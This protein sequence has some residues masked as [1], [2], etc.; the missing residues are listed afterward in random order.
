MFDKKAQ[1]TIEY[2]VIIAIVVVIALVVVGLLLQVMDQGSGIPEQ[3]AKTAWKSAEPWAIVDWTVETDGDVV[4]VL[5]NNSFET[6]GL[7]EI[8]L[9]EFGDSNDDASNVP[10][11]STIRRTIN[12]TTN[13]ISESKYSYPKAYIVIDYNSGSINNKT[14]YGAA[15]L[16]GTAPTIS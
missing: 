12:P 8:T 9:N 10:A 6:M 13:P 2:L 4:V 5:K 16:V 7:N 3:T 15:D 11:G 1:G 14:Q